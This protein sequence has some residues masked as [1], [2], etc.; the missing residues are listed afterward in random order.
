MRNLIPLKKYLNK[1][2]W[3][4]DLGD[5]ELLKKVDLLYKYEVDYSMFIGYNSNYNGNV[6]E[7]KKNEYGDIRALIRKMFGDR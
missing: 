6:F 5:E 4:L 3:S 1:E 7:F 2:H